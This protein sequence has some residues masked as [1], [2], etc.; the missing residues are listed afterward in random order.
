M[1]S[2]VA[3]ESAVTLAESRRSRVPTLDR[4]QAL[5][6]AVIGGIA[7]ALMLNG[8]VPAVTV[9]AADEQTADL[10]AHTQMVD[11][12]EG[13]LAPLANIDL[14]RWLEPSQVKLVKKI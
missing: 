13:K 9:L 14:I 10:F 5:A 7:P 12:K 1:P 11:D 6:V 4:G 8:S 3:I 2:W